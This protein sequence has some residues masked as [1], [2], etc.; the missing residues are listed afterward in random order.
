MRKRYIQLQYEIKGQKIEF[1]FDEFG[2]IQ[3]LFINGVDRSQDG[4]AID[5]TLVAVTD[6]GHNIGAD[7]SEAI[8]EMIQKVIA[9]AYRNDPCTRAK[10]HRE[11]EDIRRAGGE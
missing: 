2:D 6:A 1:E 7:L 11:L 10:A 9:N 4:Q 8:D 3:S 5:N